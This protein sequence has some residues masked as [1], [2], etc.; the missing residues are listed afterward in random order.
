MRRLV[1]ALVLWVRS[2]FGTP[3]QLPPK[4]DEGLANELLLANNRRA[5]KL[6]MSVLQFFRR[7]KAD[8]LDAL[9]ACL[10]VAANTARVMKV[11]RKAFVNAAGAA[12]QDAVEHKVLERA[13]E[14]R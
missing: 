12:Y 8:G 11:S 5:R 13:E 2:L 10:L 1:V 3:K 6:F 9:T 4:E 14:G 7:E